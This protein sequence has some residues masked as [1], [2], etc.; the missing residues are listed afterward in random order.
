MIWRLL[1]PVFLAICI[2]ILLVQA[3]NLTL[4]DSNGMIGPGFLPVCIAIL[5]LS[6]LGIDLF[7]SIRNQQKKETEDQKGSPKKFSYQLIYLIAISLTLVLS[8]ILGM[9]ISLG[10]FIFFILFNFEKRPLLESGVFAIIS[11]LI[12]YVVFDVLLGISFPKGFLD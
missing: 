8:N 12:I 5:I 10:L 11:I 7:S 1:F 3:L 6:L 9:L 4:F 2:L